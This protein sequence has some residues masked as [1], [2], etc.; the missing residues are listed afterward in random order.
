MPLDQRQADRPEAVDE[1]T[2]ESWV[3]RIPQLRQ[4]IS[5]LTRLLN[6][7]EA[8]EN[9]AQEQIQSLTYAADLTRDE[10]ERRARSNSE[11]ST[12]YQRDAANGEEVHSLEALRSLER[13]LL[14]AKRDAANVTFEVEQMDF[15]LKKLREKAAARSGRSGRVRMHPDVRSPT[16][17]ALR[18]SPQ[19][20]SLASG[21]LAKR[22]MSPLTR[23]SRL[24]GDVDCLVGFV[25]DK[26]EGLPSDGYAPCRLGVTAS[27][28]MALYSYSSAMPQLDLDDRSAMTGELEEYDV[29][30]LRKNMDSVD[31]QIAASNYSL[32]GLRESV[33]ASMQLIQDASKLLRTD[34]EEIG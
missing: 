17:P 5:K 33:G 23:P 3:E 1:R 7:Q 18:S 8:E 15:K 4:E 24:I 30:A 20:T 29:E 32:C 13:E 9:D 31:L 27:G 25:D 11:M 19:I 22:K 2:T 16:S 21:N 6:D 10:A 28:H 34:D 26:K 14:N 12:V